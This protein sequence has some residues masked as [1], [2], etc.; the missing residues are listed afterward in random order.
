M[1]CSLS[2]LLPALTA[3]KKHL[4]FT[5]NINYRPFVVFLLPRLGHLDNT[6][7]TRDEWTGFFLG[8][9]NCINPFFQKKIQMQGRRDVR[10]VLALLV[11]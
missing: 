1:V 4:H 3:H 9:K 6:P 10:S 8:K 2:S 11:Q 5:Q 7:I